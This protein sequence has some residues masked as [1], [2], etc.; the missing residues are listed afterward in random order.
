MHP[1]LF[2]FGKGQVVSVLLA[3]YG[4]DEL[5]TNGE[6]QTDSDDQLCDRPCCIVGRL[7]PAFRDR[8]RHRVKYGLDQLHWCGTGAAPG[9]RAPL[10][11]RQPATHHTLPS[12]LPDSAE[13]SKRLWNR[14]MGWS[15]PAECRSLWHQH[16]PD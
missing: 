5:E 15:P 3:C 14:S 12:F 11:L 8:P 10:R 7:D 4:R 9:K 6:N 13:R 1:D 16:F 2:V